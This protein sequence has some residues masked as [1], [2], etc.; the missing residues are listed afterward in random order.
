MKNITQNNL[1]KGF[2]NCLQ[3]VEAN[4]NT[5]LVNITKAFANCFK[6][7]NS[8]IA[9]YDLDTITIKSSVGF[10]CNNQTSFPIAL[11]PDNLGSNKEFTMNKLSENSGAELQAFWKLESTPSYYLV[12]PIINKDGVQFGFIGILDEHTITLN[13]EQ[14]EC[15]KTL[16]SILIDYLYSYYLVKEKEKEFQNQHEKLVHDLRNP[17]TIISLHSELIKIEEN[18]SD[19]AVE[20]CDKIREA[21]QKMSLIINQF[22]KNGTKSMDE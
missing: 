14:K 21:V 19:D 3:S 16:H 15:L 6:T 2:L 1:D 8:F 20:A 13:P 18:I 4:K 12:I 22:I 10:N 5:Q 11:I 17:L 7:S 9:F